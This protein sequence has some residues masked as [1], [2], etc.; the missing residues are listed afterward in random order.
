MIPRIEERLGRLLAPEEN[1]A[2]MAMELLAHLAGARTSGI[3]WG[4]ED[5]PVHL[6][7]W[8]AYAVFTGERL[9]TPDL[10]DG[11]AS[12][13]NAL[14][15]LLM[16]RLRCP[17]CGRPLS[18]SPAEGSCHWAQQGPAWIRDCQDPRDADP[19][20]RPLPKEGTNT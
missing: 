8:Y 14:G 2:L 16:G 18:D 6:A 20:S 19:A 7:R 9:A 3:A 12:A 17:H 10:H 4:A 15:L 1:D 5:G 13:A 11:P